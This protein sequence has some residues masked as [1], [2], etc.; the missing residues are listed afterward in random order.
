MH[1][2]TLLRFCMK[3]FLLCDADSRAIDGEGYTVLTI[4]FSLD[5]DRPNF[6]GATNS[7]RKDN[8]E[9]LI[10]EAVSRTGSSAVAIAL[11]RFLYIPGTLSSPGFWNLL[12]HAYTNNFCDA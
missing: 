9:G 2:R 7:I 11:R 3:P 5:P 8:S 12:N 4:Q 10:S 1:I 6:S